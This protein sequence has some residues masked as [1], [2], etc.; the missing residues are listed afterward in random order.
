MT[1]RAR[2]G[3]WPRWWLRRGAAAWLLLPLAW[4]FGALAA[5]RR[6]AFARGWRRCWKAPVPVIVVGNVTAGGAGK[7]PLVLAIALALRALG[8]TPGIV[9]RGHGRD[10]TA[11]D[12]LRV[13][14]DGDPARTGDEPLMLRRMANCPVWVGRDRAAAARALLAAEPGVDVILSDDGLQHLALARDLELVVV[15]RRG[16]GNG[17]LLPAGP[18]RE[19]WDRHRDATLGPPD[20]LAMA[21][22][23]APRF[24]VRRSLG[25]LR[26]LCGGQALPP[27]AFAGAMSGRRVAAAAGIGDPS[28]FFSMLRSSGITLVAT[29]GL[30]DHAA[31][32][33]DPLAGLEAD[34]V[35][36]TEKDA[37]KCRPGHASHDRIWVAGLHVEL[38]PRFIP[39]L[40]ARLRAPTGRRDGLS[41]A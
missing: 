7:T 22:S 13:E 23:G 10:N 20:A 18:L 38:D 6:L 16:P 4:L 2:A 29:L 11:A 1:R 19:R 28:Q 33:A 12:P 41:T 24:E 39:W 21:G 3:G 26:P 14:P 40:R 32:E 34:V 30:P 9:S 27:D 5:A 15:D 35:I 37:L 17:C 31:F 25:D 8:W 36:V